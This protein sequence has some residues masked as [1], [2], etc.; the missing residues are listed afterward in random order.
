MTAAH[1]VTGQTAGNLNVVVGD[2][3]VSTGS[4]NN[5]TVVHSIK[6]LIPHA[7]YNSA[8]GQNDIALI[9]LNEDIKYNDAVGPVCLPWKFRNNKFE[10]EPVTIAGWGATEFGGPK[11][12]KLQKVDLR[13]TTQTRCKADNPN[14]DDSMICTFAQEKDSCQVRRV[15]D[16]NI[17]DTVSFPASLPILE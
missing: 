12:K 14:A 10:N 6:T 2:H 5:S 13:T 3:D 11:S 15:V 17:G 9:R 4:E 1:C 7:N 8:T 16:T